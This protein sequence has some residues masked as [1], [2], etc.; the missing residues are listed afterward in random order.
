MSTTTLNGSV[1]FTHIWR[2]RK[3]MIKKKKNHQIFTIGKLF[4]KEFFENYLQP[5]SYAVYFFKIESQKI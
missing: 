4:F 2:Q 5:F 1:M 3:S